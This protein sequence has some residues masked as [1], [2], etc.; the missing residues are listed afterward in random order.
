MYK[1]FNKKNAKKYLGISILALIILCVLVLPVNA[2]R[3]DGLWDY[4]QPGGYIK[5]NASAN[6]ADLLIYGS[7]HY[8]NFGTVIGSSGYGI[9]DNGGSIE[10]K[11]SGGSWA[12]CASGGGGGTGDFV[13]PSSSTDNAIVRFD[14]TTGKLGQNSGIII[15]DDN[16]IIVPNDIPLTFAAT[17]G[18]NS[19]SFKTSSSNEFLF[20]VGANNN[21][22]IKGT[23]GGTTNFGYTNSSFTYVWQTDSAGNSTQSGRMTAANATIG[24]FTGLLKGASGVV[25]AATAGTDYIVPTSSFT[26]GS[27]AFG[28]SSGQLNQDNANFFWDDSNNRLGLGTTSPSFVLHAIQNTGNDAEFLLQNT[29]AGKGSYFAVQGNSNFVAFDI[30]NATGSPQN[31]KIGMFGNSKFTILNNLNNAGVLT[32]PFVI[33]TDDKVTFSSLTNGLVKSTS[34][35]LSNATA[36]TDYQ[37]PITLTTTGTS[38]AATFIANTLNIPQYAGTTYTFSTGLTNASGTITSNLSTG[39]SGGQTAIGGTGS[40]D[41][42]TLSS[43]SNGT[44]G[45]IVFGTSVYDEVN[46]RLGIGQTTPTAVLHIKAGTATASTAPL[47]FTA[48]TNLTTTEAGAIEYDGTHLYFTA[49]NAGT[50]YQL[51]QQSGS[52]SVSSVASAD[53][54]ITVTNPTTTVDLAVVKAPKWT[55]ARLLAGN[56]VDGS[57]NVPFANKFIVQGTTDAGL[58]GAQFLGALGTGIVKNTT[59]TGVLSIAAAGTDYEVPLTF[60]TGLTRTTNTVTVNTTQNISTLSNLTSNGFV[61]TS[62]GTG[63]LSIDTNIYMSGIGGAVTSGT[64]GS[65]LFVGGL[66]VLAQDNAN[67][68]YDNVNHRL[69][70]G[71]TTPTALL[72]F[73]AGTATAS[74]APLKFTAGTN[75]TTTEAGAIEYDGTHLYFT[76]TNAGTRYQLDQ[77]SAAAGLTIGTSTI[78]S[79]TNGR[80]LYDNSGVVGELVTSGA[81]SVMLRDSNS[82]ATVNNILLGYATTATAAGTT[83]LTVSS[84]QMQYFTGTTTQTVQLPAVSTLVLGQTFTIVNNSTGVVTVNSSGGNAIATLPASST[85]VVTVVAITGTTA[86]SW[87]SGYNAFSQNS[88]SL[89]T[90]KNATGTVKLSTINGDFVIDA[91]ASASFRLLPFNSD[92]YFDNTTSGITHFRSASSTEQLQLGATGN[93]TIPN[94]N[95][96]VVQSTL[97]NLVE[98]LTSSATN[99]DPIEATYQGRIATTDATV[100]TLQTVTIPSSTTVNINCAIV[101]RRTG[102][103]GGT[104]DDGAGYSLLGTYNNLA[105]TATIIGT[106]DKTSRENQ[107]GWDVD[108]SPSSGTVLI[109]VTG[110]INNNVTWHSTCKINQL[111]T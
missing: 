61:K 56:S 5:P 46:N 96:N 98:S 3:T 89:F 21:V 26:A 85:T 25:S 16:T 27:I 32:T 77:Q 47:K 80:I 24:T 110:A 71:T 74:T 10:C 63:A 103:T 55:T 6:G 82:N 68:F 70:L 28:G 86:A 34:G 23:T 73:K 33:G 52:G 79:G 60:S 104:T 20:D 99:D 49:T 94:G 1:V 7:N 90:L 44:K 87:N 67:Y 58:T 100:T 95:I 39:V 15:G 19:N 12:S 9:R 41:N 31:W 2:A 50:R 11:N 40:G 65:V 8:I 62:S 51:D 18:G 97:G 72:Q 54:S 45:K 109:R 4:L 22:K 69:G 84:A 78:T 107:A 83:T 13:G 105:G 64:Q 108:F 76:A 91:G 42:F 14:G 17:G 93:V 81:S 59:T 37:L 92:I 57:A 88:T 43:T 53:G 30:L 102:G 75:L 66:G 106:R 36:G 35:L 29:S 111:S 48:G 101:S 38:G